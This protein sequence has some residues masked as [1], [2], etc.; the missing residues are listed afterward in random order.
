M[1]S[2]GN[3]LK[4]V[5]EQAGELEQLSKSLQLSTEYIYKC[6]KKIE[7]Y[8]NNSNLA[9]TSVSSSNGNMLSNKNSLGDAAYKRLVERQMDHLKFQLEEQSKNLQYYQDKVSTLEKEKNNIKRKLD[10]NEAMNIRRSGGSGMGGNK[11]GAGI[12][13]PAEHPLSRT[14]KTNAPSLAKYN[15]LR[16]Q[17]KTSKTELMNTK[18][19]FEEVSNENTEM[20]GKI[21]ELESA[22]ELQVPQSAIGDHLS[23]LTKLTFL[24]REVLDMKVEVFNDDIQSVNDEDT[25][26]NKGE[27]EVEDTEEA[28]L[29]RIRY[30]QSALLEREKVDSDTSSVKNTSGNEGK[31]NN[32]NSETDSI[33]FGNVTSTEA[34]YKLRIHQLEDEQAMLLRYI[35]VNADLSI[36]V[37]R[38]ADVLKE[39]MKVVVAAKEAAEDK[40][41]QANKVIEMQEEEHRKLLAAA[42]SATSSQHRAELQ[43]DQLKSELIEAKEENESLNI[44]LNEAR[45]KVVKAESVAS[46]AIDDQEMEA[47]RVAELQIKVD[48]LTKQLNNASDGSSS[49]SSSS[50]SSKRI[51]SSPSYT[52]AAKAQAD[53]VDFKQSQAQKIKEMK[54]LVN[55]STNANPRTKRSTGANSIIDNTIPEDATVVNADELDGLR[56][57]D[58][59]LG[60]LTSDFLD[61]LR[62]SSNN[63]TNNDSDQ[64]IIDGTRSRARKHSKWVRGDLGAGVSD[65]CGPLAELVQELYTDLCL[66]ETEASTLSNQYRQKDELLMLS[67]SR[68][69]SAMNEGRQAVEEA[70]KQME[71]LKK[72]NR[73]LLSERD[74]FEKGSSELV[75][76]AATCVELI[77]RAGIGSSVGGSVYCSFK[78]SA[79]TLHHQHSDQGIGANAALTSTRRGVLN[80]WEDEPMISRVINSSRFS[81]TSPKPSSMKS[82]SRDIVSSPSA[83]SSSKTGKLSP[84]PTHSPLR[85]RSERQRERDS[86]RD[87]Q[88]GNDMG[89]VKYF[90]ALNTL[91]KGFKLVLEKLTRAATTSVES[92]LE[93]TSLRKRL[94]E[95]NMR[96]E[97]HKREM[98]ALK[99][100]YES[101]AQ[102]G[103]ALRDG[104][105][106]IDTDRNGG[107]PS[108]SSILSPGSKG[109][110]SLQSEND[111]LRRALEDTV[112]LVEKQNINTIA[113]EARVEAANREA[114]SVHRQAHLMIQREQALTRLLHKCLSISM[115]SVD[116]YTDTV[117]RESKD[118][119]DGGANVNTSLATIR[120][121]KAVKMRNL[122]LPATHA[123]AIDLVRFV[124]RLLIALMYACDMVPR[125]YKSGIDMNVHNADD[126]FNQDINFPSLP[127]Y[128]TSSFNNSNTN[129]TGSKGSMAVSSSKTSELLSSSVGN[130]T[131]RN[132]SMQLHAS[133]K[134]AINTDKIS[135]GVNEDDDISVTPSSISSLSQSQLRL[136]RLEE[137][138]ALGTPAHSSARPSSLPGS[139]SS[140]T[141]STPG[142]VTSASSSRVS[143][144]EDSTKAAMAAKSRLSKAQQAFAAAGKKTEKHYA[145]IS[146]KDEDES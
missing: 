135:A 92:K 53:F 38:E 112:E 83:L 101:I 142:S 49:S 75:R 105:D 72:S 119:G 81:S 33:N 20:A 114:A 35:G 100:A 132:G 71:T 90:D 86:E 54:S 123:S 6:E 96:L 70:L 136:S 34:E 79:M 19:K 134:L 32:D 29:R 129:N 67:E 8:E 7:E 18:K 10:T 2:T 97:V 1:D 26:S 52:S 138:N 68:N 125:D 117:M 131:L 104:D 99:L 44:K 17:L 133:Q 22:L 141:R 37:G 40:I 56:M 98:G 91:V 109:R 51:V 3:L 16:Q 60:Q 11:R 140:S 87:R 108:K 102:V 84:A 15:E 85:S 110:R 61:F 103:N 80:A 116:A 146:R 74:L 41:K 55:N 57:L 78:D 65:L 14:Q 115:D 128:A 88:V 12:A 143:K 46:Q 130:S 30:L 39:E 118:V 95:A 124:D 13:P 31:N 121:E 122:Y 126:L 111:G 106:D 42:D 45:E 62:D 21:H 127:S 59:H 64:E 120:A 94:T 63:N 113:L 36:D 139:S 66:S 137:K 43:M 28:M 107:S 23:L 58:S 5:N 4:K 145:K 9:N 73:L 89:V 77:D 93:S 50:S 24:R 27:N 48:D 25:S 47:S 82:P 69:H 144:P 76:V